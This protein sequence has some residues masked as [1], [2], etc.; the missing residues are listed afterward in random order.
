MSRAKGGA[1]KQG[2]TSLRDWLAPAVQ[3]R[4]VTRAELFHYCNIVIERTEEHRRQRSWWYRLGRWL[5]FG[6]VRPKGTPAQ[7]RKAVED[8]KGGGE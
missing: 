8:L 7:V 4:F 1:P 3:G 5:R 6:W 2:G